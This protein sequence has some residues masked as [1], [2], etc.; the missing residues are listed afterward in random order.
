MAGEIVARAGKRMRDR[1]GATGNAQDEVEILAELFA[2]DVQEWPSDAWLVFD[3][4]QFAANSVASEQFVDLLT[5]L[6]SIQML[7]TTRRRPSWATARRILYGEIQ[8]IDRR[9][10]AM[11]DL[12]ARA[13]LG[14]ETQS[15]EELLVRARGWPAVIGLA[16][17]AN[18]G[19]PSSIRNPARHPPYLFRRRGLPSCRRSD[20]RTRSCRNSSSRRSPA[21][22]PGSSS[23]RSSPRRCRR[24]STRWRP[25]P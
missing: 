3:D 15:I 16:G 1:I 9:A 6:T 22:S 20:A 24:L 8:E 23:R 21:A 12:E 18:Q 11:E 2:E 10:L 7:I 13:V 17:G 4:Y 5:Q 19:I 25:Q 14:S